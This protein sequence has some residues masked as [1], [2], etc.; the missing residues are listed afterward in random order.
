[1]CTAD[2]KRLAT[3]PIIAPTPL[4]NETQE[5]LVYSPN[6]TSPQMLNAIRDVECMEAI[7]ATNKQLTARL[8]RQSLPKCHPDTFGGDA[9]LFQPWK[10]AFKAMLQDANIPP[11]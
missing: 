1:M 11:D 4:H 5:G 10:S 9:T 7:I 6:T 2:W 3:V 8:V